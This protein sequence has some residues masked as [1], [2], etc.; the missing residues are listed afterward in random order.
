MRGSADNVTAAVVFL[1]PVDTLECVFGVEGETF[2]V[3]GTAY[4]SRVRMEK[5]RHLAATADEI[6]DTY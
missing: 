1:T 2:A 6:Q 4:G 3:T 5:D